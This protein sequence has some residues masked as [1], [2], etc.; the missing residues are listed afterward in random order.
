VRGED[1]RVRAFAN[2]CRHR[3]ARV[4][5]GSGSG[6]S[7]FICPYHAWTYDLRG[8]LVTIPEE[9]GFEGLDPACHGLIE[10]PAEERYG[11]VWVVPRGGA[12]IDV[13]RH[14]GGLGDDLESYRIANYEVADQRVVRRAMNWKLISDTFWEAYHIKMLHRTTVAPLFVRN[15]ALYDGFAMCHRLV[16][17]R[18]SIAKLKGVPES[19]WDLLPHATI[20]MNFFPNT[21][22]VMQTDHVETY[23]VFPADGKVNESII[24]ITVA[25]PPNDAANP[26]WKK[27]MDLL[28]GVIEQDFEI[29]EQIQ[30]NF[31][32]GVIP[33][34]E[35]GRYEPALEH[36]HRAIRRALGEPE[37]L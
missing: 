15:L 36:F 31:E 11:F 22:C 32:S 27:V 17:I 7:R 4:A 30:R 23:R 34:V 37:R 18:T 29:G 14:L 16:G 10:F 2:I 25:T 28:V 13:D 26:K 9:E 24:E 19:Q 12:H 5:A 8:Q 33:Q 3:G 21:I 35:Y 6:A 1:G 20:L